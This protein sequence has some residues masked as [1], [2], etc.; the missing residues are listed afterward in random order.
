MSEQ[1]LARLEERL[2]HWA[3][4]IK[5]TGFGGLLGTLL[6]AASPLS[7]LGAQLLWVAQPALGLIAPHDE[8]DTLAQLL[9]EPEGV[10]WLRKTLIGDSDLDKDEV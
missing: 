2:T 8:I 4:R 10:A 9:A 5:G 7:V 6:G 3:V 1:T